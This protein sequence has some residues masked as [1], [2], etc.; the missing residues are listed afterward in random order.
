MGLDS[1]PR[2]PAHV[3]SNKEEAGKRKKWQEQDHFPSPRW[4]REGEGEA[5]HFLLSPQSSSNWD[6]QMFYCA[7]ASY[8]ELSLVRSQPA[9][10]CPVREQGPD[11]HAVTGVPCSVD[12][13]GQTDGWLSADSA[14]N[15]AE[16]KAEPLP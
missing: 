6:Q 13:P 7:K 9:L 4:G 1:K 3:Q 11:R 8:H 10:P 15:L 2:F 14:G 16:S 12:G 5:A